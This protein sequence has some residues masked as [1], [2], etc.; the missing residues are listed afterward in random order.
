MSTTSHRDRVRK[1]RNVLGQVAGPAAANDMHASK[2][3]DMLKIRD[4]N[5]YM[6]YSFIC[7]D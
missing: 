2:C 4:Y 7:A 6:S 3:T 5:V 1:L